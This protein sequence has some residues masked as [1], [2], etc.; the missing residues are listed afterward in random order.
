LSACL[1]AVD[2]VGKKGLVDLHQTTQ[3][4]VVARV[5]KHLRS[6]GHDLMKP[7]FRSLAPAET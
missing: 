5:G 7:D 6:A 4:F 1:Q 2:E 3:D